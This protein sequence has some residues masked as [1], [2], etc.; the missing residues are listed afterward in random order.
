[1]NP[2]K[3]I[4]KRLYIYQWIILKNPVFHVK[5]WDNSCKNRNSSV[6]RT[7]IAIMSTL[8]TIK[9]D[10]LSARPYFFTRFS[11]CWEFLRIHE[12]IPIEELK[13]P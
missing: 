4:L 13:S 9:G 1:M 7:P 11:P 3:F 2:I 6:L 12:R 10:I 8:D 5:L